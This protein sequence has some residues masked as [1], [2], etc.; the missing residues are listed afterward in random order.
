MDD[1][2]EYELE[3]E[4]SFSFPVLYSYLMSGSSTI[5]SLKLISYLFIL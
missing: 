3:K 1:F 5:T 2:G 4:M